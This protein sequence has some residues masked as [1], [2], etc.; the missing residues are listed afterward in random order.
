MTRRRTARAPASPA[1]AARPR[2]PRGP[3]WMSCSAPTPGTRSPSPGPAPPA[4]PPPAPGSPAGSPA[5]PPRP[6]LRREDSAHGLR[7]PRPQRPRPPGHRPA[8]RG[9]RQPRD[10]HR[11]G[12]R[13]RPPL[14]MRRAPAR[15][16]RRHP[17][18]PAQHQPAHHHSTQPA[19]DHRAW[20]ARRHQP[21]PA[22]PT[23]ASPVPPGL[24][25]TAAAGT[26][27][28][29]AGAGSSPLTP[30]GLARLQDTLLRYAVSL[31]SGPT[32]LASYLRTQLTGGFFPAPSLP[33]DLGQPTEQV[34][35]HLRRAV[36]KRD[37]H[38]SFPGCTAPPVRC[39]VH[40]VIPRSQGGPT[41][42]DN[43]TLLCTVSSPDRRTPLGLDA[44]IARRRH[45]HRHQPRRHQDPA[46]PQ[47]A[48]RPGHPVGRPASTRPTRHR[49]LVIQP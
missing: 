3:T 44:A 25:G 29:G 28:P 18:R 37:R 24:T 33:L 38:C 5:R 34:P 48:T 46:Q 4:A 30:G 8:R 49:G 41:R 6:T 40:H 23:A 22:Q 36:T 2:R 13:P 47:P 39:H 27:A 16:P 35:P 21:G 15:A 1:A 9:P 14:R 43:L 32:G 26:S 17:R 7:A 11:P 19:H 12:A 10:Q 42:L 31:L 20:P 45:H